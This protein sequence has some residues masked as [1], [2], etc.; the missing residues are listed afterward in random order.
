MF[1]MT[2]YDKIVFIDA[3]KFVS[4]NIELFFAKPHMSA[5]GAG[6]LLPE[7]KNWEKLNSGLL[8]IE[9]SMTLFEELISLINILPSSTKDDQGFFQ[10]LPGVSKPPQTSFGL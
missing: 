7:N 4:Q 1:E 6:S 5:V 3:D 8:V 2:E 10:S 9:L